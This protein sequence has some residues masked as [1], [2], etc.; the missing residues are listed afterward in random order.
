MKEKIIGRQGD[1][2]FQIPDDFNGVSRQHARLTIDDQGQWILEDLKGPAG[3][4]TYVL[5][6]D[7]SWKQIKKKIITPDTRVRL[8]SIHSYEFLAHRVMVDD[9]NDYSYEMNALYDAYMA[10]TAKIEEEE[11]RVKRRKSLTKK[12][13]IGGAVVTIAGMLLN[14]VAG[15]SIGGLTG[16]FMASRMLIA[17]DAGKLNELMKERARIAVCPKC[18]LPMNEQSVRNRIC[19][20]PQCRAK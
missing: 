14:V 11:K 19:P 2:P 8:G 7:G 13:I 10:I 5:D 12:L 16:I 17:P 6:D 3:N 18:G 1:Q 4:G 20:R 15:A 9:P